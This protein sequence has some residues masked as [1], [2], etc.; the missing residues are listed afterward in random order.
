MENKDESSH[1]KWVFLYVDS[2]PAE[3]QRKPPADVGY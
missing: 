3:S 2:Q 1:A